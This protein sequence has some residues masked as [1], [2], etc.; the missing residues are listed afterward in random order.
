MAPGFFRKLKEFGK[1]ALDTLK[2]KLR[3]ALP[4]VEQIWEKT[5]P[6]LPGIIEAIP[7]GGKALPYVQKGIPMVEQALPY[8][9]KFAGATNS[10]S[11]PG[12]RLR[13]LA[14][15]ASDYM[16]FGRT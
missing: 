1:K 4:V 14:N 8:V 12:Q 2:R 13:E 5:K 9:E 6:V 15:S 7:G 3:G 11:T 16:K 10:V